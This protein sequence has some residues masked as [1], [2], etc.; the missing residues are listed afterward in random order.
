MGWFKKVSTGVKAL[1]GKSTLDINNVFNTI[2]TKM[3]D[4]KF[5]EAERMQYNK[6]AAAAM[7]E[8][9]KET[10]NESTE[11][12]QS[13][14]EIARLIIYFFLFY[15]TL[16][17]VFLFINPDKTKLMMEFASSMYLDIAFLSIIAFFFGGYYINQFKKK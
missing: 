11:R 1:F 2:T 10:M 8:Y 13:R 15:C 5:T 14:R 4:W 12:A 3:D 7:A 6:E 9:A 17:V 16:G